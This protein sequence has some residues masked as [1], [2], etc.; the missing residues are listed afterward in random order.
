MR[1]D[2]IIKK[3]F[4]GVIVINMNRHLDRWCMFSSEMREYGLTDSVKR[5]GG[6]L[7]RRQGYGCS[8]AHKEALMYAE[9]QSWKD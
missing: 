4:D 7:Y 6:R 5:I 8:V 1:L 9:S 2:K 3:M